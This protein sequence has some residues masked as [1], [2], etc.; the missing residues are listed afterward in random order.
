[1]LQFLAPETDVMLQ[2]LAPETDVMGERNY[3]AIVHLYIQPT[4]IENDNERVIKPCVQRSSKAGP[5]ELGNNQ[6]AEI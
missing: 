1:M 2:F 5:R 4:S 6:N 3:I